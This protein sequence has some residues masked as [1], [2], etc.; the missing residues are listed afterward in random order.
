MERLELISSGNEAITIF[1]NRH[2]V[3]SLTNNN[4]TLEQGQ[5]CPPYCP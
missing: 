3:F 1:E 5:I 2:D 4:Y